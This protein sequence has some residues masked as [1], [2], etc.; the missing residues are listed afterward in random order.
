MEHDSLAY[1][2]AA[3]VG[4]AVMLRRWRV[5]AAAEQARTS[6]RLLNDSVAF[7]YE[8]RS[9]AHPAQYYLG[10]GMGRVYTVQTEGLQVL[11]QGYRCGAVQWHPARW[12]PRLITTSTTRLFANDVNINMMLETTQG[13]ISPSLVRLPVLCRTAPVT[14]AAT[15]A[16]TTYLGVDTDDAVSF[17]CASVA[18]P[19]DYAVLGTVLAF[20]GIVAHHVTKD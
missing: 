19:Y 12:S 8:C 17:A 14:R 1:W 10:F 6:L 16:N 11:W 3:P 4:L 5:R 2:A 13:A 7:R 15:V 20:C 9:S 18:R